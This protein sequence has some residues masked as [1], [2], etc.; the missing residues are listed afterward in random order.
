METLKG[1]AKLICQPCVDSANTAFFEL[2]IRTSVDP[3]FLKDG[4]TPW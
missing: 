4:G 2:D 3:L 1:E